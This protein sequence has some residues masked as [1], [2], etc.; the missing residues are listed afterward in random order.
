MPEKGC[1][2][3]FGRKFS[4]LNRDVYDKFVEETGINVDYLTFVNIIQT[5]SKNIRQSVISEPEG[6]QLPEGF[7]CIVVT[8]YKPKKE[9]KEKNWDYGNSKKLGKMVP[10]LNLHS[11]GFSYAIRWY[12]VGTMIKNLRYFSLS[13]TRSMTR[14]VAKS[15]KSGVN[16][17]KWESS[18]LWDITK[19]DRRFNKNYKQGEDN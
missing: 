17:F 9:K 4:A 2:G 7:G 13:K 12:Q 15:I 10:H 6:V 3:R 16:F 14:G 18:D 1:Q 11:F 5:N 19:L 8:K